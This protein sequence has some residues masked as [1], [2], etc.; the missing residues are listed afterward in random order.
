MPHSYHEAAVR[1]YNDA[2]HLARLKRFGGGA[3]LIG[4]AAECAL[5]HAA[6]GFTS[7][8]HAVIDGHLPGDV[9]RRIGYILQ[10]RGASGQLLGIARDKTYFQ[11]WSVNDR[12]EEDAYATAQQYAE[13]KTHAD[14][15]MSVA[16]LRPG[17]GK[18]TGGD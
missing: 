1:H 2:E 3:H 5:K 18:D 6:G 8:K 16:R 7:P 14:R 4:F 13:W 9:L 17:A 12:Y 11:G 15:A 10:G